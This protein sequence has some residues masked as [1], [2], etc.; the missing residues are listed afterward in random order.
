MKILLIDDHISFCEGLIAAI[1][2][3][4]DDYEVDFESDASFIPESLLGRTDYDLFILDLMMP[5]LGGQE[6][7]KYII[8]KKIPTPVMVMSSVEEQSVIQQ[9]FTLGIIGFIPKAYSVY[10]IIEAIEHCR[11]GNI[12]IPPSFDIDL[13]VAQKKKVAPSDGSGIQLTKRQVEIL[14]LMDQG[15]SNQEIGDKLFI[16]KATVKTHINQIFKIFSASNR[17]SCLRAAKKSGLIVG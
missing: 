7:L 6:I 10:Q 12:H 16:G 14:S 8:T 13:A 4:R 3:L 11:Q 9:L 15:F 17:I 1:S 5:G 2:S